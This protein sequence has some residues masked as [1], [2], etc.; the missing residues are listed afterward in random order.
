M[1][2]T[3]FPNLKITSA[4]F[5]DDIEGRTSCPKC[6]KS[7]KWYC[8]TCYVPVAEVATRIPN[9]KV[10]ITRHVLAPS[11]VETGWKF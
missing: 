10:G 4:D 11:S 1:E 8:Y 6:G 7:R 9:I 2:E 3:P 5:L